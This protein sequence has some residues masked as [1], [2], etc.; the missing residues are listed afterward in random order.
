MSYL[1]KESTTSGGGSSFATG[2]GTLWTKVDQKGQGDS[3]W[4]DTAHVELLEK[5]GYKVKSSKNSKSNFEK[6]VFRI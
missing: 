2:S 5:G 3:V 6:N 1:W 4:K